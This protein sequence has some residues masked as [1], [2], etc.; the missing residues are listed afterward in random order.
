MPI[1]T[2]TTID[3]SLG[4]RGT[5]AFGINASG[6]IVGT[7]IDANSRDHG[8]LYSGGI[9]TTLDDPCPPSTPLHTAS[10]TSEKWWATRTRRAMAITRSSIAAAA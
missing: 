9:Y 7:Y 8:F 2:Y 4:A 3:D 5:L 10:T 6:Q 1:Y